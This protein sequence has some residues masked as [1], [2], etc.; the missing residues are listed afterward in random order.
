MAHN[1]EM[2]DGKA[3]MAYAGEVPWHGLG[4]KVLDD[5]TPAQMMEKAGLDWTVEKQPMYF[6]HAGDLQAVPGKEV[7]VRNTDGKVLDVVGKGWEPVQNTEAFDFFNEFVMNGDM[8]M[9]TAGSLQDGKLTWALAKVNE[10]F[11]LFG[12]DQVESYLMF[13]N[14]HKFGSSITVSFTPIRVV[15]NNTLNMALQ[16]ANGKGVRVTHRTAFDA[17][18]VKQLLGVAT[19][20]LNTYKEAAEFLGSKRFT[21][22]S[23]KNY[24]MEVFPNTNTKAKDPNAISRTAKT[25]LELVETQPGA[26]Y[27]EG[28]FWQAFNAVTFATDHVVGREADSRLASAWFGANQ[29]KK[30]KAL[31]KAIEYAEAA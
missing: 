9:H 29:T 15:C 13:S 16:G 14:P 26:E 10:E 25:V 18:A 20:Q 19:E 31:D 8:N 5:L 24:I 6:R 28:S 1:I 3:Q 17:D 27:A 21:D 11:E 12:G 2:I 23:L 30:L 22:E 7:L 4:T